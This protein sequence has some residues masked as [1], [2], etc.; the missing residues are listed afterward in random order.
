MVELLGELVEFDE[1]S[2]D[3]DALGQHPLGQVQ[4]RRIEHHARSL[5]IKEEREDM[6]EILLADG[7]RGALALL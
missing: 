6:V 2:S 4:V 3:L 1:L 5:A 7:K